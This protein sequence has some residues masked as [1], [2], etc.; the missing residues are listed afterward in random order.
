MLGSI[1]YADHSRYTLG[2]ERISLDRFEQIGRMIDKGEY[3]GLPVY[4]YIHSGEQISTS[5]FTCP[6]D[7]GRSGWIYCTVSA[8]LRFGRDQPDPLA[9]TMEQLRED[10]KHFND[11]I[12]NPE[13]EDE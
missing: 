1:T 3:I 9:F 4:A 7:S 8:A 2:T 5:P 12:L 6:F 11:E 13:Y 10:V